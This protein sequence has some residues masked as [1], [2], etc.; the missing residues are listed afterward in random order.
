[1]LRWKWNLMEW[2]NPI[3]WLRWPGDIGREIP[4]AFLFFW[5]ISF[6]FGCK[7]HQC[8]NVSVVNVPKFCRYDTLGYSIMISKASAVIKG[9]DRWLVLHFDFDKKK[10][11]QHA[12]LFIHAQYTFQMFARKRHMDGK[13]I[14]PNSEMC[15]WDDLGLIRN[16][17]QSQWIFIRK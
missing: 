13:V 9:R 11:Q 15:P 14:H 10:R 1:M 6:G 2:N 7:E 8:E 12:V 17:K 4:L 16:E 5:M 3:L